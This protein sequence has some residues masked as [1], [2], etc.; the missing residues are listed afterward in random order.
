M[1][2]LWK[3]RTFPSISK[4]RKRKMG[5]RKG[6]LESVVCKSKFG[7]GRV[8]VRSF[9]LS[10]ITLSWFKVLFAIFVNNNPSFFSIAI[11]EANC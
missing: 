7:P 6:R 8:S 2:G 9:Y 5:D 1:I 10:F 3:E 11:Y 4:Q